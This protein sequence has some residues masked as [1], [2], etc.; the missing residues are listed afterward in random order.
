MKAASVSVT[1]QGPN[2]RQLLGKPDRLLDLR[3]RVGNTSMGKRTQTE[4]SASFGQRLA[5]QSL[6]AFIERGQFKS[7]VHAAASR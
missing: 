1:F 3:H 4:E 7:R 2:Y 5:E 6:D